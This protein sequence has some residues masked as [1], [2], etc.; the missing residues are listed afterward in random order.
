MAPRLTVIVPTTRPWPEVRGCLDSLLPQVAALDGEI[1]VGDGHGHGVPADVTARH[2]GVLR[3]LSRPGA[4]VFDLRAAAVTAAD[5]PIIA[6]TEDHCVVGPDWCAR[7]M[8]ALDRDSEAQ[9][10]YGPIT[11]GCRQRLIDRANFFVQFAAA[12]P[13]VDM[14]T[15]RSPPVSNVAFRAEVIESQ[16]AAGDLE[17]AVWQQLVKDGRGV[18]DADAWV[19]HVQSHGFVG[20]LAAHFHNGRSTLGFICDGQPWSTR[21]RRLRPQL[22][23]PARMVRSTRNMLETK[24]DEMAEARPALPFIALLAVCYTLGAVTGVVFGPGSSPQKLV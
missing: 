12:V 10:V 3:V 6:V 14:T 4:S 23:R 7:V 11:N 17:V 19:M 22:S 9:L 24:P 18:L 8:D 5:A 21:S 2:A 20:S 16:L 1:V 13:P 15:Y